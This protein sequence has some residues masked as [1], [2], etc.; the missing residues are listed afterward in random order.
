MARSLVIIYIQVSRKIY[1]IFFTPNHLITHCISSAVTVI[2]F[3]A[4]VEQVAKPEINLLA[5]PYDEGNV[6]DLKKKN[7]CEKNCAN[8]DKAKL[9][10]CIKSEE[11]NS[12]NGKFK[13][14]KNEGK[15]TLFFSYKPACSGTEGPIG[16]DSCNGFFGKF[17]YIV[18]AMIGLLIYVT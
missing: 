13:K 5:A 3:A 8:K 11:C 17:L 18:A 2:A 16:R 4:A 14:G 9:A 1:E 7:R 10:T 15:T 12:K 6:R